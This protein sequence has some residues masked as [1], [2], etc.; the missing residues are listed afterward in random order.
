MDPSVK[1]KILLVLGIIVLLM[2]AWLAWLMF[3]MRDGPLGAGVW[4]AAAVLLLGGIAL[5]TWSR[6]A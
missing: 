1:S 5:I 4:V 3:A 6:K 2:F